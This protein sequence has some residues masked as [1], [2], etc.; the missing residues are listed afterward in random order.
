[1]PHKKTS[2]AKQFYTELRTMRKRQGILFQAIPKLIAV[3]DALFDILQIDVVSFWVNTGQWISWGKGRHRF[4]ATPRSEESMV[5]PCI[6]GFVRFKN[7]K[8]ATFQFQ[9]SFLPHEFME[10]SVFEI[11]AWTIYSHNAS[12]KTQVDQIKRIIV[13]WYR[14]TL[15][16]FKM[17]NRMKRLKKD[18]IAA[19]WHPRRVSAW[20]EAG[21]A[22]EN[23]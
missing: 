11:A 6:R 18:I 23:L 1:M 5:F 2:G 15:N 10:S 9:T 4:D 22:L 21:A 3:L 19:A 13:P 14:D 17:Q 20:L 8:Y 12:V 7:N 16:M